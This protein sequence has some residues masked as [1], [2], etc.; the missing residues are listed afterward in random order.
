[1]GSLSCRGE[2]EEE[3][4]DENEDE[5]MV[6]VHKTSHRMKWERRQQNLERVP[7]PSPNVHAQNQELA[8]SQSHPIV[9]RATDIDSRVQ[10]ASVSVA[11]H[12]RK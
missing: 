10:L 9:S 8:H 4:E 1:M 3:E 11:S 6:A 2:K 5:E 12:T 7:N